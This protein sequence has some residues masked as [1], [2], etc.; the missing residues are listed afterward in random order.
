[1]SYRGRSRTRIRRAILVAA[2]IGVAAL[3]AREDIHKA[4]IGSISIGLLLAVVA[5]ALAVRWSAVTPAA[6]LFLAAA[7]PYPV[8][9]VGKT[10]FGIVTAAGAIAI[11]VAISALIIHESSSARGPTV[12]AGIKVLL[13]WIVWAGISA[14]A[15]FAPK[16]AINDARQLLFALPLA[17]L[18]GRMFGR[19]RPVAL[20]YCLFTI[21]AVAVLAIV[22]AA[23]GFDPIHLIPAGTLSHF[24]LTDPGESYRAGLVRVRVGFYHASDLGRVLGM[25]LPVF[26][27]FATRRGA[28]PWI[29][30]ATALVT[31]ATI[32]TFTFSVWLA[33]AIGLLVLVATL[34]T[35]GRGTALA[36]T[37]LV[38][39]IVA[40][41]G[42][43]VS[44]LVESRIHPSGSSLAEENLR[45]ALI[46]ASI[47][48]ADSHKLL[49]SGPGTFTIQL[50]LYPINGIETP[51]VDDNTF[52][53]ELVEVGYPG[54]A[55]FIIGLCVLGYA[56]WRRRRIP[57]YAAAFASLVV[58]V[59]CSCTID[60]L[61]RDAPLFAGWLLLG[62]VTGAADNEP[63]FDLTSAVSEGL[64]LDK[65]ATSLVSRQH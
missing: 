14:A 1:M 9:F 42:G 15:S 2:A 12:E 44:Q 30:I 43:P 4:G 19:F 47:D 62:V 37:V 46:P 60:S 23:T 55:L 45:L 59:A 50:I 41:V 40:G 29:R 10:P 18:A 64:A 53:T 35:R 36:A 65:D 28:K 26:L 34:R 61:A 5:V 56:W 49:G 48:Y 7:V 17:Y 31:I 27:V 20:K 24:P 63:S 58:F 39:A 11:M 51:L 13:L 54:A 33:A 32:L 3:W 21:T 38:V 22:Q 8:S 52:T 6:A 57:L 25:S 16:V